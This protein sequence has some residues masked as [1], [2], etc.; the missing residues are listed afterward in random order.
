MRSIALIAREN[1]YESNPHESRRVDDFYSRASTVLWEP[2]SDLD[3]PEIRGDE[4]E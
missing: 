2:E 4:D 3:E 1:G